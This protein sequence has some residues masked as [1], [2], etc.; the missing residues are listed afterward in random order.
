MSQMG[1]NSETLST[2]TCLPLFPEERTDGV[3]SVLQLSCRTSKKCEAQLHKSL[4]EAG[5]PQGILL[6]AD[7]WTLASGP[8]DKHSHNGV[9]R[10][11]AGNGKKERAQ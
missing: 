6:S 5:P 2:S 1:P 8:A 3:A 4:G 9:G 10:D 11:G 7:R